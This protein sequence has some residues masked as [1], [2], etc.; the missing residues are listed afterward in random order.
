MK[1]T[2]RLV[3]DEWLKKSVKEMINYESTD[4]L[5]IETKF[6]S[7]EE[8]S[9]EEINNYWEERVKGLGDPEPLIAGAKWMRDLVFKK[10]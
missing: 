8:P 4:L 1:K 7:I 6:P 3:P 9:D 10:K 5:S 2:Y